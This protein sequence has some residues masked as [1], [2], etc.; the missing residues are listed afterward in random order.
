MK[1]VKYKFQFFLAILK[2][3]SW[4]YTLDLKEKVHPIWASTSVMDDKR[5][6]KVEVVKFV[7]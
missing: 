6:I 4:P 1:I 5:N 7:N 2:L 3:E